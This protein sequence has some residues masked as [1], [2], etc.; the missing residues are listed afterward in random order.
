MKEKNV[1]S[2]HINIFPPAIKSFSLVNSTYRL[3][4]LN[5]FH[6]SDR[7]HRWLPSKDVTDRIRPNC[8]FLL[9]LLL[10]HSVAQMFNF[11]TPLLLL[12]PFFA[13]QNNQLTFSN[14]KRAEGLIILENYFSVPSFSTF[15]LFSL[16]LLSWKCDASGQFV[17]GFRYNNW[18]AG[19]CSLAHSTR[20]DVIFKRM[21]PRMQSSGTLAS[22]LGA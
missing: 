17:L 9:F 4:F 3:T 14:P 19:C 1:P 21:A 20:S 11:L 2:P 13:L 6:K 5:T 8:F 16:C 10:P 7:D 15:A 18:G 12:L 22:F